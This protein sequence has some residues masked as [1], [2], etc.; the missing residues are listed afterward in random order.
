VIFLIKKLLLPY[1]NSFLKWFVG[2]APF[3]MI[4]ATV[5]CAIFSSYNFYKLIIG[6]LSN[7]VG[8]SI[9]TNL[10][11]LYHYNFNKYCNV[12]RAAVWGL[13]VMN[14]VSIVTQNSEYYNI[15]NDLYIG[16]VVLI[17]MIIFKVKRW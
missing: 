5:F 2:I 12:T 16:L 14:V 15:Y 17:V 13:L 8:Y 4:G 6:Y 7:I 1:F 11:F 9:Y 3:V 10:V